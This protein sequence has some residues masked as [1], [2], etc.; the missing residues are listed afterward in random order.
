MSAICA[1]G[2]YVLVQA[3]RTGS[4]INPMIKGPHGGVVVTR[5]DSPVAFWFTFLLALVGTLMCI[6]SAYLF[7]W[8]PLGANNHLSFLGVKIKW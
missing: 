7:F 8:Y 4:I 6:G 5:S 2:F 3:L 1:G